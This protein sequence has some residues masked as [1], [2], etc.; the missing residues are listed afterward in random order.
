[1]ADL[2]QRLRSAGTGI[3]WPPTPA[4]RLRL[5][6]RRA[7]ERLPVRPVWIALAVLLLAA[8][9]ALSV[10]AAR[11]AILRVFHLGGVTVERVDVLP[12]AQERPLS[13]GL[14]PVVGDAAVR[15]A[16]GGLMRLP[17]GTRTPRFHLLGGVVSVVLATPQPIV[18]SELRSDAVLLKKIAGTTTQVTW[19]QVEGRPAI[20]IT[21][22][23]HVVVFP[24]ASARLAGNA[25]VW[26]SG[27]ITY[28]LEGRGL[29]RAAALRVAAETV[30]T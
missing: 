3:D 8:A 24:R 5:E 26:E 15:T 7:R 18:L 29:S 9:V 14:G 23:G 27:G 28:R 16:L 17:S 11:S 20:W 6:P 2:E 19:L 4:P 22:A 1:M 12:P 13:A 30:G 25:L 10:P 21:G